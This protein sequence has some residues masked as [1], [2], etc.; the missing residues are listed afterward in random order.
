MQKTLLSLCLA[1]LLSGFAFDVRNGDYEEYFGRNLLT[2]GVFKNGKKVGHWQFFYP[3]KKLHFEGDFEEN[4]RNGLW[5]Y[6]R[7]DGSKLNETWYRN[8]KVDSLSLFYDKHN[9]LNA[10]QFIEN[11][12]VKKTIFYYEDGAKRCTVEDYID[13]KKY[14]RFY[15]EGSKHY[16]SID[17]KGKKNDTTFVYATDGRLKE[18]LIFY[19]DLLLGASYHLD[20]ESPNGNY[21]FEDGEGRLYRFY[22]DG[23]IKSRAFYSSGKKHGI[24]EFYHTNGHLASAGLYLNGFK[25]G[26]WKYFNERGEVIEMREHSA[27]EGDTEFDSEFTHDELDIPEMNTGVTFPGGDRSLNRFLKKTLTDFKDLK[28]KEWWIHVKV[29]KLGFPRHIRFTIPFAHGPALEK[30]IANALKNFPRC[31]PAFDNG[32]PVSDELNHPVEL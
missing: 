14:T 22:D 20:R 12:R 16:S 2:K 8:D 6:Y 5:I 1:L 25:T 28:G 24:T 17:W 23:T 19:K 9:Q 32:R 10:R 4:K 11:G 21:D 30:E 3:N 18:T 7:R 31:K 27:E 13:F 26:V 29:D 15:P